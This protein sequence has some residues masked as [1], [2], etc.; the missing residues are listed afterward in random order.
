MPVAL[1][2]HSIRSHQHIRWNRQADLLRRFQ[3]DNELELDRLLNG[4]V[5]GFPAFQN[6]VHIRS[7]APVQVRI[8]HAVGHKPTGFHNC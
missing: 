7:G 8:V 1:P 2:D 4:Q 6:L 3:V 5:G